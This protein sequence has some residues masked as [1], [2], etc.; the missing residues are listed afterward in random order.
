LTEKGK[1]ILPHSFYPTT[2]YKWRFSAY[3]KNAIRKKS[4]L[5]KLSRFKR[6]R[7]I[8]SKS[9]GAIED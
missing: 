1:G 8:T 2:L 6:Y 7:D 9:F 5:I 3:E 4:I